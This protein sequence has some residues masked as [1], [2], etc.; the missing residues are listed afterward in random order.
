MCLQSRFSSLIK[1]IITAI[2]IRPSYT[3]W[4]PIKNT[5]APQ[6]AAVALLT[7]LIV[8]PSLATGAQD[9]CDGFLFPV[10]L[11]KLPTQGIN[12]GCVTTG[13]FNDDGEIDLVTANEDSDDVSVL[14]GLGNGIF[15]NAQVFSAGEGATWVAIGDF[16][17]DGIN[18]LATANSI[19]DNVSILL[20]LGDG[21]FAPP[22]DIPVG[23]SP[24]TIVA[25]DFDADGITDLATCNAH[26]DDVS[27]LFGLGDGTFEAA[28]M[29][30]HPENFTII[31]GIHISGDIS[32]VLDSDDSDLKFESEEVMSPMEAP[33]WI[34]FE[35]D[36]SSDSPT[37]LSVTLEASANTVGII[38]TIEMFNWSTGQYEEV[39]SQSA[40]LNSDSVVTVDLTA[41]ITEYVS[42]V[43]ESVRARMGWRATGIGWQICIDQV[44]WTAPKRF[45]AGDFP[46]SMAK[47]D[48][49]GDGVTDLA[50]VN[51]L[52]DDVSLHFG[53][54]DGTFNTE[55][56]LSGPQPHSVTTGDF[57][58]DGIVDLAI[59]C[60]L[61]N[62]VSVLLGSGDGSF[63]PEQSYPTG[64]DPISIATGD[65][66]NDGVVD[67]ITGDNNGDSGGLFDNMSVLLG[68][69]DG[70]FGAP[71]FFQTGEVPQSLVAGDFNN[72][73][74]TDLVVSNGGTDDV[75]VRFGSENGF[76]YEVPHFP[77]G[78]NP[79]SVTTGD[80][81]GDGIK[82]LATAN[83]TSD[84]VSV[85]LGIGDG[86]FSDAVNFATG[87]NPDHIATGDFNSDGVTDLATANQGSDDIS[88]L[89]GLGSTLR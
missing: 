42:A 79:K 29:S 10:F 65:I 73:G 44:S 71:Q 52:S 26:T 66:N 56:I 32:S 27:V 72:D 84:D 40:S 25:C 62:Q 45:P 31:H 77:T 48:F 24:R 22:I 39:D 12:P 69:G 88:V 23:T 14:L 70:S 30:D 83:Q 20:G 67:L 11:R 50:T 35:G 82:D 17:G 5:C 76:T 2:C 74:R 81:N 21:M 46:L 19:S 43:T 36:L 89:L 8:T 37:S 63:A 75:W 6:V 64:D 51:L 59:A 68:A 38:Q 9:N 47:G 58:G 60:R 33:V 49:N 3:R 86:T 4:R 57:N 1:S 18:D 41:N 78:N 28:L 85:L 54:G 80:F 15:E 34:V 53:V 61:V 13:D 55:Q 16:N 87:N 7:A